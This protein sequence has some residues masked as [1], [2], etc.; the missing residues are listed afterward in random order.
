MGER[1]RIYI[2][3]E[4]RDIYKKISSRGA[5]SKA[6]N[7]EIFMVAFGLGLQTGEPKPFAGKSRDGLVVLSFFPR[8][9]SQ[10]VKAIAVKEGG[11]EVLA[12]LDKT[13]TIAEEFANAGIEILRE[14][15]SKQSQAIINELEQMMISKLKE[16]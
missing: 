6:S 5:F 2:L 4:H 3:K 11:V 10:L 12:D 9:Y 16:S 7:S 13:Y 1:D 15:S 8:K 14:M